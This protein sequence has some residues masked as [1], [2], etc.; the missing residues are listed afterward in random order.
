MG[1]PDMPLS[2]EE[3]PHKNRTFIIIYAVAAAIPVLLS[4]YIKINL[5]EKEY[6]DAVSTLK[7]GFSKQNFWFMSIADITLYFISIRNIQ[8]LLMLHNFVCFVA[9]AILLY[10]AIRY[11][12]KYLI[13]ML[14][15]YSVLALISLNTLITDFA[16]WNSV[17]SLYNRISLLGFDIC[18]MHGMLPVLLYSTIVAGYFIFLSLELELKHKK[19]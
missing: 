19:G 14:I 9:G 17:E 3:R 4:L 15:P 8:V 1:V 10:T 7:C 5:S 12:K 2:E 13:T 11:K 6:L 18:V 16:L